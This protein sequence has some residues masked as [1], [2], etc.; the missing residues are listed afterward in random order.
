M[1]VLRGLGSQTVKCGNSSQD[2]S[3]RSICDCVDNCR[4]KF[5]EINCGKPTI[6]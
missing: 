4:N 1:S 2:I 5:D 6:K 3:A